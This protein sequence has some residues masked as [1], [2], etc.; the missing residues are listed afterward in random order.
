MNLLTTKDIEHHWASVGGLFTVSNEVEYDVAVARVNTLLDEI[1]TDESHPLYG[2]L[3]AL[4]T[5]IH[6]YEERH[7]PLPDVS[8]GEMLRF[9]MEEQG[10]S[11]SDLRDIG[12]QGVI[13][14]ILNGK[15]QLNV[16]QIR[17]LAARFRVST[18]VFI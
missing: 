7:Q 16:R 4:A 8:G 3:D 1:G 13:S 6:S 5:I 11:Q 2:F 14:E 18:A 17:L 12:S 15:R 9:F 10:L